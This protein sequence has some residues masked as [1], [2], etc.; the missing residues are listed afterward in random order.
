VAGD[1]Y[2]AGHR[3]QETDE[4]IQQAKLRDFDDTV[5]AKMRLVYTPCGMGYAS[6]QT[7][8]TER[9]AIEKAKKVCDGDSVR[10]VV[11]EEHVSTGW[12]RRVL[13]VEKQPDGHSVRLALSL[14]RDPAKDAADG[15]AA[16]R[17]RLRLAM[18]ETRAMEQ[19]KA[20][21]AHFQRAIARCEKYGKV[22]E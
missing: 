21:I 3:D 11:I 5:P 18:R 6:I 20:Q 1:T 13:E 19:A 2:C 12:W 8:T 15:F 17:E 9:R 7:A 16:S 14:H 4:Q 10:H 22:E